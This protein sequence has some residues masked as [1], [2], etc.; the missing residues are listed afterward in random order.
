MA[1]DCRVDEARKTV[2]ISATRIRGNCYKHRA[3]V[4]PLVYADL[5]KKNSLFRSAFH[6]QN[7]LSAGPGETVAF[8]MD[9]G[10]REGLLGA[11]SGQPPLNT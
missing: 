7:Y 1:F 4:H 3:W 5:I 8:A 9:A 2:P 11:A 6:R 10:V